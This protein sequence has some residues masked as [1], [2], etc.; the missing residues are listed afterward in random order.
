MNLKQHKKLT[1]K[2]L[3]ARKQIKFH[4][5]HFPFYKII[6]EQ[7]LSYIYGKTYCKQSIYKNLYL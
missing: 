3:W 2:T 6:K 1:K 5:F 7:S 4:I